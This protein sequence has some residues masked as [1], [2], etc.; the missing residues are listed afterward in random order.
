V[1]RAQLQFGNWTTSTQGI[2]LVLS[3]NG[4]QTTQVLADQQPS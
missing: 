3:H 1:D 4:Q 2:P